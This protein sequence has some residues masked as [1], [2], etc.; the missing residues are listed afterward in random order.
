[1]KAIEEFKKIL[2]KFDAKY[3]ELADYYN[4][5]C[6]RC[7]QCCNQPVP[8][9]S[10]F[11]VLLLQEYFDKLD[12]VVQ[13]KIIRRARTYKREIER[14]V[15]VK[16]SSFLDFC[17]FFLG[18]G[19][20]EEK[21][22]GIQCPLLEDDLCMLYKARPIACRKYGVP[23]KRR[24]TLPPCFSSDKKI[25]KKVSWLPLHMEVRKLEKKYGYDDKFSMLLPEALLMFS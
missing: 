8:I 2:D 11:E 20:E 25:D 15:Y 23:A 19:L 17:R 21:L 24:P 9:N 16:P 5:E 14:R 7:G 3:Q 22:A 1:M 12:K 13:E 6:E 4:F 10:P 18:F